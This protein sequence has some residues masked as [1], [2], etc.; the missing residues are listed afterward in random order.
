MRCGTCGG[1][2][3]GGIRVSSRE[4]RKAWAAAESEGGEGVLEAGVERGVVQQSPN[5]IAT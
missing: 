4:K 1:E 5:G 2:V 3:A